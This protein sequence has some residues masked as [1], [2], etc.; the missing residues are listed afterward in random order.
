[1]WRFLRAQQ[2]DLDG[3]KSWCESQDP[4]FVAKAADVVG[5]ISRHPRMR[6][7]SVSTKKPSIQALERSQGHLKL[8]SGR[9]LTGRSHDYKRNGTSTL[10]AAFEA[11]TGKVTATHKNRRRRVEFLDFMNSNRCCVPGHGYSRHSRQPQYPQAHEWKPLAQA[12]S[13]EIWFSILQSKSLHGA[14]FNAIAQLRE[15]LDAFIKAYDENAKSF[16]RTKT[17]VHQLRVKGRRVS[18]L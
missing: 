16:V 7:S 17:E 15:H 3:R 14:S 1:V 6:S 18:Q 9:T 4:D 11:A 12:S 5:F 2:I 8:P 13:S 10:F